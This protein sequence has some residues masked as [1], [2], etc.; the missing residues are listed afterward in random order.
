MTRNEVNNP[1]CVKNMRP[2]S[3][4]PNVPGEVDAYRVGDC[5]FI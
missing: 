1:D 3:A 4:F 5:H 2:G